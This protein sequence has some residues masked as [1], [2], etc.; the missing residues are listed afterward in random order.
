MEDSKIAVLIV[1]SIK[2]FNKTEKL[3]SFFV[4]AKP[5]PGNILKAFWHGEENCWTFVTGNTD[6]LSCVLLIEQP[7]PYRKG[8]DELAIA[9][10]AHIL[11]RSAGWVKSFQIA[12][13]NKANSGTSISGF[14]MGQRIKKELCTSS[15]EEQLPSLATSSK[16]KSKT[17]KSPKSQ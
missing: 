4:E 6:P 5:E 16:S 2:S 3:M 13:S 9:T 11:D 17:K 8:D 14:I 12:M 15:P 10:L 1:E 7:E